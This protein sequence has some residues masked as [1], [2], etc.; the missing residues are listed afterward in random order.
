MLFAAVTLLA[1]A[2]AAPMTVADVLSKADALQKKGMLAI[3]S[4]DLRL[5]KAEANRDLQA[6]GTDY[7]NARQAH[8]PLPACPP[9]D[10]PDSLKI[11]LDTDELLKFYRT[12]PPQRRGMSSVQAFAE[13]MKAKF[14]C[15]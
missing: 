4:S 5:I 8:R 10:G 15:R 1:A 6:F 7:F 12:I 9:K 11:T 2:Q 3:F 14:P 13:F